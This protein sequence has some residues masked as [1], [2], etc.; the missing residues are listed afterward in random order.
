VLDV[1]STPGVNAPAGEDVISVSV[2][3]EPAALADT[4]VSESRTVAA[5]SP[6]PIRVDRIDLSPLVENEQSRPT[7]TAPPFKPT[8]W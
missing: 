7:G 4:I 2:T 3:R 5:T 6:R 1:S 8:G